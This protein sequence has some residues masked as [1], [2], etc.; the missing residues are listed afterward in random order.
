MVEICKQLDW[1]G[2]T[3]FA[4]LSGALP[5]PVPLKADLSVSNVMHDFSAALDYAMAKSVCITIPSSS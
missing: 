2:N 3:P 1:R 5:L 4:H